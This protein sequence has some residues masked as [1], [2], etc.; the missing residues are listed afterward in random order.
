MVISNTKQ[1][2]KKLFLFQLVSPTQ[3]CH[4][5]AAKI[6]KVVLSNILNAV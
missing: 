2:L 1:W 6:F 3:D 5:G 4:V